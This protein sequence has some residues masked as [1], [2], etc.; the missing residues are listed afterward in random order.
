MRNSVPGL[1][2]RTPGPCPGP[3]A[4]AKPLSHPGI[5]SP[6]YPERQKSGDEIAPSNS[7]HVKI[8]FSELWPVTIRLVF[9][10]TLSLVE[11]FV[12]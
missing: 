11:A 12:F 1:D 10:H 6:Q 9:L 3:K 2:P 5:P 4:G 8:I 7:F